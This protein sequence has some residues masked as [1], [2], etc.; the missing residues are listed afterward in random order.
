MLFTSGTTGDPKGVAV[1]RAA[2]A[3][4]TDWLLTTH[5]FVPGGETFLNQAPFGFDLSVM[6]VYGALLTGGTLVTLD[7]DETADPRRLFRRLAG[8]PITTWVS[9]PS[10]ARLCLSEPRFGE[11]MLPAVRRFLF[12]GETLSPDVVRALHGRFPRAAVWNMYGPT[13]ATVAVTAIEIGPALAAGDRPLPVGRVAPGMD[14]WI[15]H[16]DDPDRRLPD[17]TRGEIV[18]AGPQ[19]ACGYVR[20]TPAPPGAREPFATLADGRRAYR[21]GDLGHVDPAAGGLFCA[22]RVDRQVKLRGYRIELEEVEAHLRTLAG[23]ADAA[24]LAV[25]RDGRPDHLVAFV[26]GPEE[27]GRAL[28]AAIRAGLARVLPE[29]AL[30]RFVH[31]VAALPL[32]AQGKV[33]RRSLLERAG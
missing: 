29:H 2:L 15:A 14:V 11:A 7:R 4:F 18:V 12:C 27:R 30:P 26:V 20:A 22:G 19:L 13:E 8:A 25:E 17:R 5:G 32:T 21:T 33:D 31:G 24:V 16:P 1:P 3:H 10:F 9:T 6:D 23:V 28:T